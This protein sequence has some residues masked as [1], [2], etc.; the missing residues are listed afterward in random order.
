VRRL[1]ER[2]LAKAGFQVLA[3]ATP[4]EARALFDVH[5]DTLTLLVSD[6]LMPEMQGPDLANLLLARRPNLPVLFLSGYNEAMPAGATPS[7]KVA[8]LAKPFSAAA[9]TAA[10]ENLLTPAGGRR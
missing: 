3:A 6:V 2:L 10:I 1:T 9:L 7:A 8:F 4:S 5:G